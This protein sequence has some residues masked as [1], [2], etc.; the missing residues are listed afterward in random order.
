MQDTAG[1]ANVEDVRI[2]RGGNGFGFNIKGTTQEGG[3]L[4]AIGG[5]GEM[6]FACLVDPV[7]DVWA[8]LTTLFSPN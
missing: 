6:P 7:T 5:V 2:D 1:S 3:V 8:P 4:Q